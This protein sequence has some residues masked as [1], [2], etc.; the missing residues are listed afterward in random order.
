MITQTLSLSARLE[1]ALT[2]RNESGAAGTD[3]TWERVAAAFAHTL[4]PVE[5]T[6]PQASEA[7]R[8]G[9]ARLTPAFV[10]QPPAKECGAAGGASNT[11]QEPN[12]LTVN[13][14]SEEF[15][16]ISL[17]VQHTAEGTRILLS[18]DQLQAFQTLQLELQNLGNV[19]RAAGLNVASL[20]LTQ[21]AGT[22]FAQPGNS[23]RNIALGSQHLTHQDS[24][25]RRRVKVVG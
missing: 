25:D 20:R 9:D 16:Q 10:A 21:R 4:L 22:A 2:E 19:L 6:S 8:S 5:S 1:N 7:W 24:P 14:N 12:S 18:V 15:G 3:A 23:R 13:L 17:V 11:T